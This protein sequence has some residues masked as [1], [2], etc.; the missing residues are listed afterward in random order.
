MKTTTRADIFKIIK[1][2]GAVR[3]A[4]LAKK[5]GITTQAVHRHLRTL[6]LEGSIETR[7]SSPYTEYVVVDSP[8][9]NSAIEWL[10]GSN[11]RGLQD[12]ICETRDIFAARLNRLAS[13]TKRGFSEECLPLLISATGEVG[14]NS[15]DHNLGHWR[16]AVGCWFE[17]VFTKNRVWVLIADQGQGV[18]SSLSR[19]AKDLSTDVLALKKAFEEHISGRAPENRGNGL[20]FVRNIIMGGPDRGIACRSGKGVVHYGELGPDCSKILKG[21]SNNGV[22]TT[23]IITWEL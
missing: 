1:E 18:L 21:I 8:D 16:D 15:F 4:E 5:L 13:L 2:K 23:T 14:N 3:P 10:K 20:K 22:G 9:F 11:P 19:V 17:I 12:F 6:T 7:G